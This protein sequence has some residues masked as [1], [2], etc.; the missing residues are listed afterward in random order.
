MTIRTFILG[1]ALASLV[2]LSGCSPIYETVAFAVLTD[3]PLLVEFDASLIKI[4]VGITVQ[5]E[6]R[7][8]DDGS[9]RR[10]YDPYEEVELLSEDREIVTVDRGNSGDDNRFIFVGVRVGETCV[11]VR[12]DSETTDCIDVQV[13]PQ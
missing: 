12:V 5:V 8:F 2:S 10:K 11:R 4:P 6:V 9:R 13:V 7:A 1:T 3:P